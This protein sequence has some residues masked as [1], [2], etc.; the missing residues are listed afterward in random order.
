MLG[1]SAMH[2][3][4][5]RLKWPRSFRHARPSTAI[6]G[7][8]RRFSLPL[9]RRE[10]AQDLG[11]AST[12]NHARQRYGSVLRRSRSDNACRQPPRRRAVC[13][14]RARQ[15]P[16]PQTHG[17]IRRA[18]A[19]TST[20]RSCCSRRHRIV[21]PPLGCARE[22][23]IESSRIASESPKASIQGVRPHGPRLPFKRWP[24]RSRRL[25]SARKR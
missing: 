20:C 15:H 9:V 10:D 12:V 3:A 22:S 17:E 5:G 1:M 14:P 7:R 6:I 19:A 11:I 21:A 4:H 8:P 25:E 16:R 24:L 23:L 2:P 13:C 18:S